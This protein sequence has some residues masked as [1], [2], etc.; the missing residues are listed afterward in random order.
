[1]PRADGSFRGIGVSKVYPGHRDYPHATG[2]GDVSEGL[3]TA[4]GPSDKPSRLAEYE[5]L[6]SE[7]WK[8]V[9]A[10]PKAGA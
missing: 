2:Q 8:R 10:D 9:S 4:Y 5:N 1:M 7:A 3:R 6:A